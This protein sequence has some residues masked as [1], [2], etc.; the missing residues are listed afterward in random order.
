MPRYVF[1]ISGGG[2]D[3]DRVEQHLPDDH[4]AILAARLCVSD[5]LR[6]AALGGQ[7]LDE[8]LQVFDA[9][10][11]SIVRLMCLETVGRRNARP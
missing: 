3:I 4:E 7:K 5:I 10:G 1:E 2:S 8:T 11:R 6:D 9:H